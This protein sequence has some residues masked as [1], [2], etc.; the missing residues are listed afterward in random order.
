MKFFEQLHKNPMVLYGAAGALVGHLMGGSQKQRATQA[1][2]YGAAGLAMG[3]FLDKSGQEKRQSEVSKVI[4]I[5]AAKTAEAAAD[6]AEEATAGFGAYG[7]PRG[8][9]PARGTARYRQARRMLLQQHG[10]QAPGQYDDGSND[11]MSM[12]SG[13][14]VGML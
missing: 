14:G 6:A 8:M 11:P 7:I 9:R 13:A 4:A 2:L 12:L 10:G 5:E 3:W 1:A